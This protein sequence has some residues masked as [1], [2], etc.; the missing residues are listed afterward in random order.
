MS[1][2]GLLAFLF[3][4]WS[5]GSAARLLPLRAKII[6]PKP[7]EAF[8]GD[9]VEVQVGGE[10]LL[11]VDGLLGKERIYFHSKSIGLLSALVGVDVE[12]KP[13]TVEIN[14]EGD[15]LRRRATSERDSAQD[16]SQGVS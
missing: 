9:L 10:D 3:P 5:L 6:W 15:H 2:A 14:F 16:Q 4:S 11:A 12:A 7:L 8:Q 13:A 1:R